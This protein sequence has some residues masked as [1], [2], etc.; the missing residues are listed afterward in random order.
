[1]YTLYNSVDSCFGLR[2]C[3][4]H[5]AAASS[6][7]INDALCLCCCCTLSN[8]PLLALGGTAGL[9]HT[10]CVALAKFLLL[11]TFNLDAPQLVTSILILAYFLQ[12]I[13]AVL[14]GRRG[15]S[16]DRSWGGER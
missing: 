11:N 1:M 6:E 15:F 14:A 9:S 12:S 5:V 8:P 7:A 10:S 4:H 3:W 2:P 16:P 13:L